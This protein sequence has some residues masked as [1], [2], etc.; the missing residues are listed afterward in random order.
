MCMCVYMYIDCIKMF[1]YLLL[2]V[3]GYNF[4]YI[5]D[6]IGMRNQW[7][8]IAYYAEVHR[9]KWNSVI[10]TLFMPYTMLG[11]YISI[12]AI[13]GL[14]Q[15]SAFIIKSYIMTFYFG[16]YSQISL[17]VSLLCGIMYYIPFILS[18]RLYSELY[19]RLSLILFG[20]FI[21]TVSL[22]I[23]EYIG[24]YLGGDKA[25]RLEAVPNAIFYAMFFSVVHML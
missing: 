8:G 22:G 14:S 3:L 15:N 16:L 18:T 9:S 24:H 25:S 1:S 5:Q 6:I 13:L 7:D 23:Q 19:D 10:H 4:H 20:L 17:K 21:S 2:Y 12:P 11:F